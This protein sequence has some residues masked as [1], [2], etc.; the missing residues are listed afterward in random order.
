M[1]KSEVV[2]SKSRY[3]KKKSEKILKEY[4]LVRLSREI[5]RIG[6]KEVLTGKA[7]FGIFGDGKELPQIAMANSFQNGDFRSGY[8]RDQTF[9]MAIGR[10]TVQQF[11]AQLYGHPDT[12]ADPFSGGRQMNAHFA[13][14]LLDEKGNWK[15]QTERKNSAADMSPTASHIPRLLGLAQ[16]SK[17]YRENEFL[18]DRT[19]FSN[20]GREVAFG[21][22]GDASTSEGIFWESINAAGVLQLP[23]VLSVWDDGYGISVSK[24]YQTTKESISKVLE[25]FQRTEDEPGIEIF[26]VKA[27]DYEGLIETYRQAASLAREEYVPSLIHVEDVTQPQG[28]S[29]SGSHERYKSDERLEWEEEYCCCKQFRNWILEQGIAESETLDKIEEDARKE[30]KEGKEKAWNEFQAPIKKQRDE[31]VSI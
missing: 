20:R 8:Y 30:A 29:T 16:A 4:K 24:K 12:K 22:I 18:K 1:A 17:V 3:S 13:T 2:K 23:L 28:H 15:P 19:E 27:W 11:F 21:T 5:S 31:L 6:R 10:M 14:R 7:K 26:R 25:G 9:M